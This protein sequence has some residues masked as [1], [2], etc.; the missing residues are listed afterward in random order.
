MQFTIRPVQ[1]G[2]GKGI[3]ALRRMP[4]V[5]ENTLGIPSERIQRNE[6]HIQSLGRN[7]HQFVAVT[8]GTDGE[9]QIIGMAGLGVYE[10]PRSRHVAGVGIMVHTEYQ[11]QGVGMQLM[12]ALPDIADNWLMLVRMELTV[13]VDN[14]PA[15][16]MYE[17]LGFVIEG[18]K[19]AEAVRNGRYID[20]YMMARIQHLPDQT[21]E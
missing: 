10:N 16:A 2:D 13:L 18:T 9:E 12:E 6:E 20:T 15:I 1:A 11:R 3:N 8:Q 21:G 14:T 17:K 19:R 4:G 5:F 7:D